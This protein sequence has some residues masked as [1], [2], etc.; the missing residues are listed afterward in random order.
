M[1]VSCSNIDL[2]LQAI[3]E[4]RSG[5]G[6][7]TPVEWPYTQETNQ[8]QATNTRLSTSFAS[9]IRYHADVHSQVSL[10]ESDP[11]LSLHCELYSLAV[12]LIPNSCF[13]F[14]C[15]IGIAYQLPG[16]FTGE[17]ADLLTSHMK[18][19]GLLDSARIMYATAKK[20]LIT[21]AIF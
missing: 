3:I 10:E 7:P 9:M 17:R 2:S 12:W 14:I 19:M 5:Q 16:A 6:V 4:L 1:Y 11:F 15:F 18:A 8:E 21:I 13:R 20:D